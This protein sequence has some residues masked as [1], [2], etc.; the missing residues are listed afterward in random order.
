MMGSYASQ[1]NHRERWLVLCYVKSLQ[2]AS[3][4]APTAAVKTDSTQIK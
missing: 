3:K 1:L 4:P 2:D